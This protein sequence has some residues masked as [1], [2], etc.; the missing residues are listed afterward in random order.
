MIDP[1]ETTVGPRRVME[2]APPAEVSVQPGGLA[3]NCSELATA[4][5]I[6]RETI[7]RGGIAD[8][9]ALAHRLGDLPD[10]MAAAPGAEPE[11]HRPA[12]LAL[13]EEIE[14]LGGVVGDECRRCSDALARGGASARA[15]AAYTKTT[16]F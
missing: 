2:L 5:A 1:S 9:R 6:A 15:V 8:L 3:G 10:V 12:L 14:A 13:A 16:R 4:V 7:G 11:T